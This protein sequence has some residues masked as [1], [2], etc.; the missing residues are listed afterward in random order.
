MAQFEPAVE[1]TLKFEGGLEINRAD[2]GGTTN[3]GISQRAFP[4]LDIV[5]LTRAQAIEI[6]R[7][8]YW[9]YDAVRSQEVANKI[10]DMSVNLGIKHA[11]EIVQHVLSIAMD[12]I[13][14]PDTLSAINSANPL[15]LLIGLRQSLVTYYTQLAELN[16]SD[17]R[18]LNGWLRRANS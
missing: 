10:F 8:N 3:F 16:P 12:G 9:H 1:N 18:F 5:S 11:L 4:N 17:A 15:S 7:K 13:I 2:A 6:Y 14:G